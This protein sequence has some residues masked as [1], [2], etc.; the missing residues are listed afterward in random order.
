METRKRAGHLSFVA[1][2][3]NRHSHLAS[4]LRVSR[5]LASTLLSI[6][7][8][9]SGCSSQPKTPTVLKSTMDDYYEF[10][11]IDPVQYRWATATP[12]SVQ[13]LAPSQ[14]EIVRIEPIKTVNVE[15]DG[16]AMIGPRIPSPV[17]EIW[18]GWPPSRSSVNGFDPEDT[19]NQVQFPTVR[20][21]HQVAGFKVRGKPPQ[22]Q[23]RIAFGSHRLY[24]DLSNEATVAMRF[25]LKPGKSTGYVEGFRVVYKTGGHSPRTLV[26]PSSAFGLCTLDS[27]DDPRRCGFRAAD[28]DA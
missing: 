11:A 18:R 1:S 6:V 26:V 21:F 14:T 10:I 7:L 19:R 17:S 4:S 9:F 28:S 25:Q 3:D 20:D 5:I 23:H 8:C 12:F 16:F 2:A 13:N 22:P 27:F 15:V 24:S